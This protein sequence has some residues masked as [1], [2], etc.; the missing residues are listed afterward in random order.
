MRGGGGLGRG[1]GGSGRGMGRNVGATG[2]A[3]RGSLAGGAPKPAAPRPAAAPRR[4]GGG[5]SGATGFGLGLGAGMLLGGGGRRGG[6]RSTFGGVPGGGFGGGRRSRP[7]GPMGGGCSSALMPILAVIVVVSVLSAINN[8]TPFGGPDQP[9]AQ[10]GITQTNRVR[11]PLP[12]GSANETGDLFTDELG[13]IR[14]RPQMESG[15]QGFFEETGV[16]PHVLIVDSIDGNADPEDAD[17]DAFA[18]AFYLRNFSDEAHFLLIFMDRGDWPIR[19]ILWAHW[20]MEARQVMDDNAVEIL[21]DYIELY[22]SRF[23]T[24]TEVSEAQI[25]SNA[26]A[27]TATRIMFRPPDYR[28]VWITLFVVAGLVLLALILFKV[29]KKKQEYKQQEAERTERILSQ[30][31]GTFGDDEASRLAKQYEDDYK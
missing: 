25:F 10:L 2:R 3:G 15:L 5:M 6:R 12:R 24:T 11:D 1:T 16:R 14:N 20:G 4:S 26:F 27:R 28:R 19:P 21:F 31:L 29:W 8:F 7:A 18:D 22:Y 30:D 9:E 23:F 13:W 17:L